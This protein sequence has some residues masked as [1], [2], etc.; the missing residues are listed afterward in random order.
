[1]PDHDPRLIY[2][3][4][5]LLML[6][7]I[8]TSILGHRLGAWVFILGVIGHLAL[9]LTVALVGYSDVMKRPWPKV[10]PLDDE[11]DW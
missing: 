7:G 11:D 2:A 5:W 8:Y 10:A 3:A 6:A 1:V 4:L 9:D